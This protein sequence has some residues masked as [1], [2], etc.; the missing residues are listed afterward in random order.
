MS[1]VLRQGSTGP[2]V[3]ALQVALGLPP[4]DCDSDFGP[5]TRS[6]VIA[7][8]S[9]H[10]LQADGEAGPMTLKA[11]GLV[12]VVE[13]PKYLLDYSA[14]KLSADLI[15]A[16]GYLG[17]IRYIDS[18]NHWRT[19]HTDV[20]DYKQL[21][22]AGLHVL[23]VFEVL[24]T[25]PDGG[26]AA[27]VA[28]AT[29]AKAGADAIGYDGVI[30]FCEDRP[31]TPSAANW[32]AYLDGAASVLG[33]ERVGAYGFHAAMD[34]AIGHASLF[35]QAGRRVDVRPHVNYWQDNN[36]QIHVDGI[37][38]DRNLILNGDK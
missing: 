27:G 32:Q 16:G 5:G 28:N 2:R 8:Q 17:A 25:D 20:E 29:R 12:E 7:Y 14:R 11:L 35:W 15:R 26:F 30:F 21:V 22:D 3:K 10:G 34:A 13:A 36:I 37:T 31:S 19:K 33:V 18:P 1:E 23:L 4:K 24:T 38:C 6:A 9:T